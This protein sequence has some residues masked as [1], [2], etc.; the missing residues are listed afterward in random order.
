MRRVSTA[1]IGGR[2]TPP[3]SGLRKH[4]RASSS[5]FAAGPGRVDPGR[6]THDRRALLRELHANRY[7]DAHHVPERVRRAV[8]R[9]LPP[10]SDRFGYGVGRR[11]KTLRD[12]RR[13]LGTPSRSVRTAEDPSHLYVPG[14]RLYKKHAGSPLDWPAKTVKAGVHG[15]PGGST[16]CCLTTARHVI[17]PSRVRRAQGF[18]TT[19][20]LAS[21]NS[22]DAPARQRC[23]GPLAQAGA[24]GE[25]LGGSRKP[26]SGPDEASQPARRRWTVNITPTPRILRSSARSSSSRGSA[27]P[28]WSTTISTS[29]SIRRSGTLDRALRGLRHTAVCGIAPKGERDDRGRRQRPW[30]D[31]RSVPNPFAPAS[32]G[33]IRSAN[34]VSSGWAST[35]RPHVSVPSHGSSPPAPATPSGWA[36]RSTSSK[37]PRDFAV[38]VVRGSEESP[39]TNTAR[40]SRCRGSNRGATAAP[41]GAQEKLRERSAAFTR[42]SSTA[43]VSGSRSTASAVKPIRHCV[44]EAQ[45]RLDV[46]RKREVI[47]ARIEIDKPLADARSAALR[48]L[49]GPDNKSCDEC[50]SNGLEVRERRIWGWVGVQRY[51]DSRSSESTSSATAGRS[52]ASTRGSSSGRDPDD[53]SGQGDTEYPIE[54]PA[55]QG[56]RI[57]GEIHLDHVPVIY[58][59]DAFDTN[60]RGWRIAVH[61]IRG[62]GP[63]LPEGPSGP[64]DPNDSPLAKLHR[65]YRRNDPGKNYLTPGQR[66]EPD[67]QPR[68]EEEVQGGDP[69]YQDDT[70]WWEAVVKH[71]EIKRPRRRRRRSASEPAAEGSRTRRRSSRAVR[72]LQPEPRPRSTKASRAADRTRAGRAFLQDGHRRFPSS[73]PSSPRPASRAARSN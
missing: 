18:P 26:K 71:E 43:K 13:G 23:A 8:R 5:S 30:N 14:A 7:W 19:R 52:S 36:S 69:D 61:T 49:A 40:A 70:K 27:S 56:G 3:I 55:N 34:S 62:D 63:L 41:T 39:R 22:R 15:S 28:S 53:P 21:P 46:S 2:L 11:W 68:L 12:L 51:L 58:T 24:I 31:S 47:P 48:D 65:G 64:F 66:Q 60:D 54:P 20:L 50:D 4:A 25:V 35:S 9:A 45:E 10:R 6:S 73:T 29:S 57:V 38:P 33:T 16:L 42:T 32:R 1:C 72:T 59:K 44:W 37:S 67:R 17:S